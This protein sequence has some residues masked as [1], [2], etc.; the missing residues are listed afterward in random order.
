MFLRTHEREKLTNF[1]GDG[2]IKIWRW[3]HRNPL[4]G[5]LPVLCSVAGEIFTIV[6]CYSLERSAC[7]EQRWVVD[8]WPAGHTSVWCLE[9]LRGDWT[10]EP[11][12]LAPTGRSGGDYTRNAARG[13]PGEPEPLNEHDLEH[14]TQS[15]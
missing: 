8:N 9:F 11:R 3:M 13:I 2:R 5:D 14:L 7:R 12:Y 10:D 1:R 15:S 4:E 6:A